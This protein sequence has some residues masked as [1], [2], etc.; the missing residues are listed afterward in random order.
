MIKNIMI[1]LGKN[2]K[3]GGFV[4]LWYQDEA[5]KLLKLVA[6]AVGL[7]VAEVKASKG[8]KD[9]INKLDIYADELDY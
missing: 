1:K 6:K 2:N 5:E 7:S 3:F 9:Y 8:Y 4:W